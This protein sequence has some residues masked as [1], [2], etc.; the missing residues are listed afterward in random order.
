MTTTGISNIGE[1]KLKQNLNPSDGPT[2][3]CRRHLQPPG[4]RAQEVG[5]A[6]GAQADE[7]QLTSLLRE[8]GLSR[9]RRAT[10]TPFDIILEA[11]P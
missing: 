6:L 7:R 3:G 9:V 10:E 11:T 4:S 2:S 8:A 1:A 5:L